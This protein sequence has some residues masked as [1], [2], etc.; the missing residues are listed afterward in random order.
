M[1]IVYIV[2]TQIAHLAN[3][4]VVGVINLRIHLNLHLQSLLDLHSINVYCMLD[5][6]YFGY[7]CSIKFLED[8]SMI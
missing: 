8:I 3:A 5:I 7:R 1:I 2:M 6:I 4:A